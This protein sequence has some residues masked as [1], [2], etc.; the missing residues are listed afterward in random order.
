MHP[1]LAVLKR[2]PAILIGAAIWFLSAQSI[3]P[4]P[5]GILGFDKLQ[6]LAAYLVL[7]VT[8]GLWIPSAWRQKRRPLTLILTTLISSIYGIVDEVHQYYVPGRDCNVWDWIADTIGAIIGS[9][10]IMLVL[11]A[12]ESR[13]T[14]N[15]DKKQS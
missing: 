7:A 3:L 12:I 11:P 4:Q 5:K 15:R 2:F 13:F 9:V 14:R 8:I 6:H 10:I 1:R